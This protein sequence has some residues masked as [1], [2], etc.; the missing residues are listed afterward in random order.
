MKMRKTLLI[1]LPLALAA[2]CINSHQHRAVAYS[3]A[4]EPVPAPTSRSTV[5]RVYPDHPERGTEQDM[6]VALTIRDMIASDADLKAACRKVDIEVKNR[7]AT[8]R[9]AVA[10]ER[11]R[12]DIRSR[13]AKVQGIDVI[14]D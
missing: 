7:R 4:P 10:T 13:L 9:G 12:D 11:E 1:V 6:R 5:V 14:E 2:G 3:T 8:L